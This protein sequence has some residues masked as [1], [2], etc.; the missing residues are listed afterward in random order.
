[1]LDPGVPRREKGKGKIDGLAVD[2]VEIHGRFQKDERAHN[3]IQPIQPC[4]RQGYTM[5]H[6]GRAEA[7][8]LLQSLHREGVIDSIGGFGNSTQFMKKSL[9]ARYGR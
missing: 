9:F 6:T 3:M 5:S 2:R 4:M 7:F 1:M 8:A